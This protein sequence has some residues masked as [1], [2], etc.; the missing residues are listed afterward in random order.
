MGA[1]VRLALAKLVI[2][3][4]Y[5]TFVSNL[6]VVSEHFHLCRGGEQP[7]GDLQDELEISDKTLVVERSDPIPRK[8]NNKRIP[9]AGGY[10]S[11][12]A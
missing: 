2:A 10:F 4:V 9:K 5:P 11:F 1:N 8:N 6:N 3:H 12:S 7:P